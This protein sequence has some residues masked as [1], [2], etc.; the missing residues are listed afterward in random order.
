MQRSKSDSLNKV[1]HCFTILGW[2]HS[3]AQGTTRVIHILHLFPSVGVGTEI[4][5]FSDDN[6]EGISNLK[7]DIYYLSDFW[8]KTWTSTIFSDYRLIQCSY[9]IWTTLSKCACLLMYFTC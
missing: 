5:T 3:S 4:F 8:Q 9:V 7:C 2:N 6:R 1:W